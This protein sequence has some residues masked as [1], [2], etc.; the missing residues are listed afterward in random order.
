MNHKRLEILDKK[1]GV[2]KRTGNIPSDDLDYNNIKIEKGF[3][4]YC[5]INNID[6]DL[7]KLIRKLGDDKKKIEQVTE[8]AEMAKT[9]LNN[10]EIEFYTYV[11]ENDN[12]I[13]K[14]YNEENNRYEVSNIL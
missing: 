13:L 3:K 12:L 7:K 10:E 5:D 8:N 14:Y 2:W 9:V 1:N 6:K 4:I 11:D